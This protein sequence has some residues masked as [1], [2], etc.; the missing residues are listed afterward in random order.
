[1]FYSHMEKVL[2]FIDAGFL[3]K[4]SKHFGGGIP[5]KYDILK[6]AK[7]IAGKEGLIFEQLFY[8]TSPPFQ[9][10]NPPKQE[11]ERKERYDRF[12]KKLRALQEITIQEGRCQRIKVDGNFVYNQKGV[13]TL[14]T[15]DLMDVPLDHS[16]I[17]EIILI[18][19]DSDFVPVIERLKKHGI[20]VILYTYFD[21][22]RNS[23]FSTSNKLLGSVSRYV[24][25][26]GQDFIGSKH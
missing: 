16:K 25:I 21:R 5:L 9:S 26:T 14:L 6:F 3:S 24:Q 7:N 17:K 11:R 2:I 1:M 20:K 19:S 12:I 22:K 15:M 23:A 8:Y 13:D 10:N 4:V 18:A